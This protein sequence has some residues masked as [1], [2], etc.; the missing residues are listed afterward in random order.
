[1]AQTIN[2]HN[3]QETAAAIKPKR[4]LGAKILIG[5]GLFFAS[6][7]IIII[8]GYFWLDS[9]NGHKFIKNQIEAL[10][11]ENGM[12]IG[13]GS[14]DGSIYDEMQI[15]GLEISDPKGIFI[16]ADAMNMDWRPFA[17]INN[18]VDIRTLN[19]PTARLARLPEFAETPETDDPIL[20]DWD[21]DIAALEIGALEMGAA[22]TGQTHII[23]MKAKA[24]IADRR[25]IINLDGTA[26]TKM[27]Q[28]SDTILGGTD[29]FNLRINAVPDDNILDIALKLEAPSDGM[30]AGLAGLNLPIKADLAGKGDW[31][32]WDGALLA[33]S[34][35][36]EWADISI[37]ARDGLFTIKGDMRPDLFL[38]DLEGTGRNMLA[39]L[40]NINV[41][42]SGQQRSF[43]IDADVS[44]ENFALAANG[45]V[46]LADN[47]LRD[48]NVDFRLLKPSVIADTIS[49]QNIV[50]TAILNGEFTAPNI[51]Y[52]INAAQ[53]SFDQTRIL[54]LRTKGTVQFDNE[55]WILPI[56]ASA[57]RIEG[58]DASLTNLLRDVK[59]KGDFAY[60]DG[61]L[62]SD[63]LKINT[64]RINA[65]AVVIADLNKGLYS[66]GLQGNIDNYRIDSVAIFNLDSDIDLQST[67]NG[68]FALSG[69]IKA[70]TSEILNDGAR[71]FL[72]GNSVI[73]ANVAYGSNG[74]A[75]IDNLRIA[76]PSFRLTQ[77]KGSYTAA[78]GIA[79]D[80][81]AISDQYGPLG[82][83]VSGT[84][85][86]P[87]AK[88]SAN[89]P[90]LGIG[91]RDIIATLQGNAQGYALTAKGDSDYGPFNANANILA[92][93]GPLSI[94]LKQGSNFADIGLRGRITQSASGPF[95]G[96]L[97]ASGSGVNGDIILSAFNR[98]QRAKIKANARNAKLPGPAQLAVE[99]AIINATITL[100]DS[101]EIIA[102]A[103]LENL[104]MQNLLIAAARAD[105]D[106][107]G[108]Q[109]SAKIL[110]EGRSAFPF[111][112]A[113]NAILKPE[114]WLVALTGRANSIDFKTE[115]AARIAI[116]ND[117][118]ILKPTRINLSKGSIQ[119]AGDFG[120][121]LNLQSRLK[122]VDLALLNPIFP[123][124]GLGGIATGS[125]D[126]AQNSP[127]AFPSADARL[128][129]DN[130]T[131]SSI[132][133]IS[134]PVDMHFV[135]RLLSDGGN[136]RAIIRRRGAAIG[137]MHF[138]LTPL[139]PGAGPWLDRIMAAPLT[140]GLRY[141]GPA[142]TLFSLAALPDQSLKGS[143]GVAADFSGR[144]QS[145][146][147]SGVVR[148]NNLIYEN[149][150]F[151]T[152]LTNMK[153]IGNFTNDR[154]EVTELSAKAG[155]GT[156]EGKG[157]VSLSSE[158]GFPL[159]LSLNLDNATLASG[160]DL[161]ASASG[162]I[163]LVNNEQNPATI[164]GRISLPETRYKIVQQGAAQVATLNGVRRKPAR[165]SALGRTKITGDAE[166]IKGVPSDWKLNVDVVA[167]NQIYVTGLGLDSE[168]SADIKLRGTA[169]A[170]IITGGI[171]LIRG[172]LD[173]AG[174]SFDLETGILRFSGAA[175][176]NPT[177][178][179]V[180]SGDADDVIVT[181][182]ISGNALNPDII[183]SSAP[184]LPQDEI[185]ARI[186][187]GSSIA[188]LS[189][190]Q[191][192]QLASSLNAL[193]AGSGGLNPV[194]VLQSSVGI[195]RLRILGAD[196]ATGR[197][198]AV[199]AGQYIS[200]DI[201]V[202][203]ISDARG[204]TATQLE[205]SLTPALSVLSSVG[206]FGGSNIDIRYRKDY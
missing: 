52:N 102:K 189:P 47:K 51:I 46:N 141:N 37:A 32:K 57:T 180:A 182:N 162:T 164:S 121:G 43:D 173:F 65:T 28:N 88:L 78:G 56:E 24:Q 59:I 35:D 16:S 50:A 55:R 17:F 136:G 128:K 89:N 61:R 148:A 33:K 1:M 190:I 76:A 77:G 10:S 176:P 156:I 3:S 199:A 40:T 64:N 131:R 45:L 126:F 31:A 96:T 69:T 44:N 137:R 36:N 30:V 201:Y 86:Q 144:V 135:G 157:F 62:L 160:S 165:K 20:P 90:D 123:E 92:G 167:E 27:A 153:I 29:D 49:G 68:D 132:A 14:I 185:L 34:R 4:S 5:F 83:S 9:D 187:F 155:N 181:I 174:R 95:T 149:E 15:N 139:P 154:L 130:F 22:I 81:R 105:I 129:I 23:S 150:A 8:G 140:G 197:G 196:E 71:E 114:L 152:R 104:S 194:S 93:Q 195:D 178:R 99:R 94:D 79:F 205:I 54:G 70:R 107:R 19:I 175:T 100:Y 168:W 133:S 38:P 125:L 84:I 184:N 134:Q 111:R 151:G 72:G 116:E 91:A 6:L 18:H 127:A 191:A 161:A 21:I 171:D 192:V 109:G 147:L 118:Y 98:V 143:I 198:T 124:L 113:A 145:P 200:D 25:A 108:G 53:L 202:E 66:G 120:R 75:R 63:N 101:P 82:I 80:A 48:F 87:V 73:T 138:N 172:T 203:I 106:Y 204:N 158:K 186:L 12:R 142:S 26:K 193:R 39:A 183:F 159:Q 2:S 67:A 42:L 97:S 74:L 58:L 115:K 110:A 85:A 122:N 163:E 188:T 60:A 41:T 146:S 119:I 179:L 103:Q 13:I 206:S 7:L 169:G 170:P 112:F 177:L 166:P 117:Q 11:F